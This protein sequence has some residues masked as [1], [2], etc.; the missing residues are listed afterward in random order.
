M[1]W[2]HPATGERDPRTTCPENAAR[3]WVEAIRTGRKTARLSP[4]YVEVRYEDLV[5]EPEPTLMRLFAHLG[6]PYDPAVLE[7]HRRERD[8]TGES[9]AEQVQRPLDPSAV[10][11]WR[12]ALDA[13]ALETV[14]RIAGPTLAELGYAS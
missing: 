14:Q 6:V 1:K 2:I 3:Y 12:T 10:G 5:L 9:S 13:P 7:Y 8:L 11:R 4:R